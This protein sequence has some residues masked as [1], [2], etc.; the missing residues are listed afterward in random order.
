[1]SQ[2]TD[3]GG[4]GQ[5]DRAGHGPATGPY[6]TGPRPLP[7]PA[8][9]PGARYPT[10]PYA[11]GPYGGPVPSG[12]FP[13]GQ[14]TGGPYPAAPRPGIPAQ[15]GPGH[16]GT[17]WVPLDDQDDPEPTGNPAAAAS[18]V[19]GVLAL[20]VSLRPLAFG[21]MSLS[22]DTYVALGVGVLALVVGI[23]GARGPVRRG[24]AAAGMLIGLAA[25]LVVAVLPTF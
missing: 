4:T 22:W 1:M 12:R 25:L 7:Q 14:F 8:P 16:P 10:G 15:G 3:T 19:L 23:A 5:Q 17:G 11:T 13:A 2:D 20:L 18:V 6:A 9:F 24:V 21:T